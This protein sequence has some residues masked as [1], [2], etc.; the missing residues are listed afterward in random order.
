MIKPQH[1]TSYHLQMVL[2]HL[3]TL[4]RR[5]LMIQRRVFWLENIYIESMLDESVF[6]AA[7]EMVGLKLDKVPEVSF[8]QEPFWAS[9]FTSS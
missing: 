5:H 7:T 9:I 3:M 4:V 2:G 8:A 6:G 1:L